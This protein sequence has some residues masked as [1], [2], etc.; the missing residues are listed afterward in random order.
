M[1]CFHRQL[2]FALTT[3]DG[4]LSEIEDKMVAWD[5]YSSEK[6]IGIEN[7][8]VNSKEYFSFVDI[9]IFKHFSFHKWLS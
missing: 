5:F 2:R 9:F 4:D 6:G 3:D 8:F 1:K 7:S